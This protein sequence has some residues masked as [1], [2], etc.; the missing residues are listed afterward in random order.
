[1]NLPRAILFDNDGVLAASEPLHWDAW[2]QLISELGLPYHENEVR[3]Q[4]GKT[5]PEII[6]ALLAIHRPNW[7]NETPLLDLDQLARRKNDFF[8]MSATHALMPYPGVREGIEWLKSQ[9]IRTAVV[10][11][12]KRRELDAS[13]KAMQLGELLEVKI[14][15]DD[16]SPPKPDPAP[17]LF[18][19]V[20]LGVPPEHCLV[21]E[22]SPVG[23]EAGLM[24]KI[25]CAAVATNFT[26]RQLASPVPGRP[27]LKPH[28]IGPS[29]EALFEWLKTLKSTMK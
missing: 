21:V 8:L 4:V 16:V 14:S 28:W 29:I 19:A 11:N 24:G 2:R 15:R 25:P 9:G 12:A 26:E 5:G 27:D 1:M 17:Y 13:L 23:L 10:T 3:T 7:R 20:S 22:D 6:G 18:A